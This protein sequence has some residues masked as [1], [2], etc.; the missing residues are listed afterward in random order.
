MYKTI[1]L[2]NGILTAL[3]STRGAEL[4]SLKKDNLENIWDGNPKIWPKHSPVP[5]PICGR[6]K[7]G[8]Y[9]YDGK[10]YELGL[11][12]FGPTSEYEVEK[13]TNTSATF[14]LKESKET[15]LVY[16]FCFE[17]R[18]TYTLKDNTLHVEYDVTNK[19]TKKMYFSIGSHE[20]YSCP[21]GIEEYSILFNQKENLEYSILEGAFLGD[22]TGTFGELDELQ[23]KYD[24]FDVDTLIFKKIKSK[25]IMLKNRAT[26]KKISISFEGIDNLLIWT[27]KGANFICLELWCGLPD[28]I[29]T[30]GDITKKIGILS[31]EP[32]KS[33]VR[34]HTIAF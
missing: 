1:T 28:Y 7:D 15:L 17:F 18:V 25:D 9:T 16:P 8:K 27:K 24:Y 10:E 23:L 4:I 19:D 22:E 13:Q 31:L 11:H 34:K 26:G 2:S 12:G 3:I 14:L 20:A 30:D 32:Q 5:F 21:E 6:L 33:L 29:G